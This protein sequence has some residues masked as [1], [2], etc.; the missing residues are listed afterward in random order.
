MSRRTVGS[1]PKKGAV[2][3]AFPRS[4]GAK[5]VSAASISGLLRIR[6]YAQEIHSQINCRS[7]EPD[8]RA[9]FSQPSIAL[10]SP[11]AIMWIAMPRRLDV[12]ISA[13]RRHAADA[14]RRARKLPAGHDRN[15]LRQ[16]AMGLLWLEKQGLQPAAR[17]HITSM[18]MTDASGG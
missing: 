5:G 10:S 7:R 11:P 13:L 14:L 6:S 12:E 17:D 3:L 2:D 18:L 8:R 9:D 15:D 1:D 16:L 4:P